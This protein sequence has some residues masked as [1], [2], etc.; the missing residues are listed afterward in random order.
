MFCLSVCTER[1]YNVDEALLLTVEEKHKIL[2]DELERLEKE[3]QTV[4]GVLF[5]ICICILKGAN[6][7]INGPVLSCSG[8]SHDQEDGKD[9]DADGAQAAPELSS[10]PGVF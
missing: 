10:E 5:Y 6:K 9:E 3:S 2:R 8:P 4:R 7:M 1:M